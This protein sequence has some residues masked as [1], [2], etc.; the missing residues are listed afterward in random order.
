[1]SRTFL[2][3]VFLGIR[4]PPVHDIVNRFFHAVVDSVVLRV[5]LDTVHAEVVVHEAFDRAVVC[6]DTVDLAAFRKTVTNYG[7]AMSLEGYGDRTVREF[8]GLACSSV[9]KSEFFDLTAECCGD[10]LG[11]HADPVDRDGSKDIFHAGDC[12]WRG[13]RVAGS[14]R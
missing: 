6:I 2:S 3:E 5:E 9:T 12:F 10:D 1:M 11:S 14:V 7:V 8:D 4:D 13:K